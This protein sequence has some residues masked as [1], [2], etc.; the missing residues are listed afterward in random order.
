MATFLP[1]PPFAPCGEQVHSQLADF[2]RLGL[3]ESLLS[4]NVFPQ[5]GPVKRLGG[6]D[7]NSQ[8]IDICFLI[9]CFPSFFQEDLEGVSHRMKGTLKL[10]LLPSPHP[11]VVSKRSTLTV[12]CLS[13]FPSK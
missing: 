5:N 4:P 10:N 7:H 9:I 6:K 11:P 13:P 8:F 1:L 3:R 12:L 2:Y